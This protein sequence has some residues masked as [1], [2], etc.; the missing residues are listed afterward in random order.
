M[1]VRDA[2]ACTNVNRNRIYRL[3]ADGALPFVKVGSVRLIPTEA[4]R[5]LCLEG[6]PPEQG[7]AAS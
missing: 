1:R 7:K 5:R 4:L 3:M 2:V 6:L